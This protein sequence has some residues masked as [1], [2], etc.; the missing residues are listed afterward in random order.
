MDFLQ[1]KT[2][3]ENL[4]SITKLFAKSVCCILLP[5][6]TA[7]FSPALV[8]TLNVLGISEPETTLDSEA[9][10]EESEDSEETETYFK[11]VSALLTEDGLKIFRTIKKGSKNLEDAFEK[12]FERLSENGD[13]FLANIFILQIALENE[14]FGNSQAEEM[15][16]EMIN[17]S[18]SLFSLLEKGKYTYEKYE[19]LTKGMEKFAK[20]GKKTRKCLPENIITLGDKSIILQDSPICYDDIILVSLEDATRDRVCEVEYMEN[21]AV[22]VIRVPGLKNGGYATSK[23]RLM[24]IESGKTTAYLDDKEE[25]FRVPVLNF[26]GNTYVPLADFV[27]IFGEAAVYVTSIPAVVIC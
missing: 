3:T 20:S 16:K 15:A 2:K 8:N 9:P 10:N 5:I 25:T 22:I 26:E 12:I 24:E 6:L 18:I 7:F 27:K 17:S 1:N 14:A 19:E 13:K 23:N 21:N 4:E 11:K